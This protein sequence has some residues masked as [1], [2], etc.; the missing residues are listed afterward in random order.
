MPRGDRTGPYG[1]GHMTGRRMGYC[2][3]S[4]VPGYANSPRPAMGMGM[5]MGRGWRHR[6]FAD[7]APTGRAG[8]VAPVGYDPA[9]YYQPPLSARTEARAL[10]DQIEM[11]RQNIEDAEKRLQTLEADSTDES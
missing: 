11:M 9:S 4:D 2:A 7:Y 6:R 1:E 5:G 10:R 8:P 3:G